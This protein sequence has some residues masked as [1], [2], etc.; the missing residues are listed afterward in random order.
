[1]ALRRAELRGTDSVL[2]LCVALWFGE[3]E[4]IWRRARP[5]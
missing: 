1:M 2:R 4:A 5:S 3:A